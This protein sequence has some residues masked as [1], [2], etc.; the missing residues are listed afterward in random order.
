M[1]CQSLETD[2]CKSPILR[3]PAENR[4]NP[5]AWHLSQVEAKA[6]T[7]PQQSHQQDKWISNFNTREA[8]LAPQCRGVSRVQWHIS[9][10]TTAT[11]PKALFHCYNKL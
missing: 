3:I 4:V 11:K 7:T 2:Q 10:G 6:Y 5:G 9:E 1:N 8:A